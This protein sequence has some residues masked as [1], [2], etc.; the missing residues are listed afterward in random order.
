MN[1][2]ILM[3]AKKEKFYSELFRTDI[4]VTI[5]I[6]KDKPLLLNVEIDGALYDISYTVP[7]SIATMVFDRS[8]KA[9]EGLLIQNRCVAADGHLWLISGNLNSIISVSCLTGDHFCEGKQFVISPK[10]SDVEIKQMISKA[11]EEE[12]PF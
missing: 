7:W 12:I 4:T 9:A 2:K 6:E 11:I 3:Y 8:K 1:S 10:R 5:T